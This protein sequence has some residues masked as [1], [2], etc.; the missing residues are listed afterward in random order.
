MPGVPI[1]AAVFQ[2]NNSDVQKWLFDS[3]FQHLLVLGCL[4]QRT[5]LETISLAGLAYAG[6]VLC[7]NAID[8]FID[9]F[10]LTPEFFPVEKNSIFHDSLLYACRGKVKSIPQVIFD[11]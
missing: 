8:P 3:T 9:A 10:F 1:R 6:T 5:I 2:W 4:S 11:Q 7:F